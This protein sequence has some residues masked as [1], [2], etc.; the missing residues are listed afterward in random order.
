MYKLWMT[1]RKEF[2]LLIRDFGGLA[3]LFV[4]PVFLVITV[5]LIQNNT[6]ENITNQ[7]ME[8][9]LVDNDKGEISNKLITE[10]KQSGTFEF[11]SSIDNVPLTEQGAKEAVLKGQYQLAIVI[12]EHLSSSLTERIDS[13][14]NRVL[15][16]FMEGDTLSKQEVF[17]PKEVKLYFDPALQT[18]FKEGIKGAI[19]KIVATIENKTIYGAFASQ[20]SE[21]GD[22]SKPLFTQESLIQFKEIAPKEQEL[23]KIPNAVQHNVPAWSLFAIFFIIVPLGMNIVKE[24]NQG[25]NIR[26]YTMPTSP[27]ITLGGK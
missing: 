25:T 6:Y 26:L 7:K 19:D 1:I 4:M 15:A 16:H 12:P 18:S 2:L 24:K 8:I 9:L 27:I 23:T 10:V 21:E 14:V 13:N 5:T 20:L 22:K 11:I 17:V 3:I